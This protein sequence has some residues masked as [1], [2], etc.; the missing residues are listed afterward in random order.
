[1][2]HKAK[3]GKTKQQQSQNPE[4]HKRFTS[5]CEI[6]NTSN[7]KEKCSPQNLFMS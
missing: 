2:K 3:K 6:R 5:V 1:M 7:Y 4:R